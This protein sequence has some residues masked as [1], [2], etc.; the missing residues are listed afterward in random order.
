MYC[1]GDEV[2]KVSAGMDEISL[3]RSFIYFFRCLTFSSSPTSSVFVLS[4]NLPLAGVGGQVGRFVSQ[5]VV[6]AVLIVLQPLQPE[7]DSE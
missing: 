6:K 7:I 1:P 5:W 2:G 3:S 4:A